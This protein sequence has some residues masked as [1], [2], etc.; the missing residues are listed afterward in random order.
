[1][2]TL[3]CKT[4]GEEFQAK[5]H[6]AKYCS[7]GCA[8]DGKLLI[9]DR[10]VRKCCGCNTVKPLDQ[11]GKDRSKKD[12]YD[13]RCLDCIRKRGRENAYTP[14]GRY[15]HAKAVA[16]R[17]EHPW[18]LTFEQYTNLV[19]SLCTYCNGQ[20]NPTSIGLDRKDNALGYSVSNATP[21]CTRCNMMKG[22][23]YTFQEMLFLRRAIQQL[24]NCRC[25]DRY[26][27]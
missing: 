21:C 25:H 13:R 3:T 10:S 15:A 2:K 17:E 24:E 11:F 16:K 22:D 9:K 7:T 14:R 6:R 20:V 4:C 26:R 23:H 8:N 19:S 5:N 1:M 18:E 12:G 27:R